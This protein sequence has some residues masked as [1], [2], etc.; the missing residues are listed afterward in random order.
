MH[1]FMYVHIYIYIYV[2]YLSLSL[3]IYIYI[4]GDVCI[5]IYIYIHID[6]QTLEGGLPGERLPAGRG[7]DRRELQDISISISFVMI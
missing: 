7:V 5:Y 3:S 1:I 6:K 4:Y 2:L